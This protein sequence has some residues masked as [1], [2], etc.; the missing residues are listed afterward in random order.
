[1]NGT[2]MPEVAEDDDR[3]HSRAGARI[4]QIF[5]A[6]FFAVGVPFQEIRFFLPA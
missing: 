6:E 3:L 4:R 2:S 1:M 5:C